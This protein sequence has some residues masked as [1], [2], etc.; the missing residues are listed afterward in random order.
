LL[1]SHAQNV[2]L[3]V[4]ETCRPRRIVHRDFDV[5]VD[6]EARKRADLNVPFCGSV[7]G[8]DT[9]YDRE[10]YYSLVY[11][12]FLG[13]ELLDY[14]LAMLVRFF[15]VREADVRERVAGEF[16]RSFPHPEAFFPQGA[17]YYFTSELLPGNELRLERR[18]QPPPWR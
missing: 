9:A 15:G 1:E 17:T 6:A 18:D 16:R 8:R 10:A 4:D 11:D 7:I 5:W 2:L 13:R 14:L 12:H 3:E